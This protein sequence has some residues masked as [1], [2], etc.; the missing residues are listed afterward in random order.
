MLQVMETEECAQFFTVAVPDENVLIP[1]T[2][3][4]FGLT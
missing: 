4:V 3:H 2:G 1:D